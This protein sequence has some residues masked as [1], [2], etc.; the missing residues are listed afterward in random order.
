MALW[1]E[2]F[3]EGMPLPFLDHHLKVGNSLLG[4][5]DLQV[6]KKGIASEAFKN[7]G[8]DDKSVC[9]ALNKSNNE[10]VRSL[11][12]L[13]DDTAL[14]KDFFRS[15]QENQMLLALEQMHSVRLEDEKSKAKAY[16]QYLKIVEKSHVKAACDLFVGAYMSPKTVCFDNKVPTSGTV[17]RVLIQDDGAAD[18]EKIPYATSVC[19]DNAVFHWPIEF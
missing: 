1:L 18:R 11:K 8:H 10:S 5:F 17:Y 15:S 9:S 12:K 2:G 7:A 14:M 6:L 4:I 16:C 13:K 19:R 3:A